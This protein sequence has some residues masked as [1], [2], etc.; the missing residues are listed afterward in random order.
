MKTRHFGLALVFLS[1]SASAAEPVEYRLTIDGIGQP[2]VEARCRVDG[3]EEVVF[4]V[5]SSGER[6]FRGRTFACTF[7][8]LSASGRVRISVRHP[9]GRAVVSTGGQG[10]TARLQLGDHGDPGEGE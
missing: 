4:A 8:Q 7:L 9:G 3:W 5:T 10:A 6:A 1:G 2:V